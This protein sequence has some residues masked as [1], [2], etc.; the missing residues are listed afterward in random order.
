MKG[1]RSGGSRGTANRYASA[2]FALGGR[3]S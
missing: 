3:V 2:S 1:K